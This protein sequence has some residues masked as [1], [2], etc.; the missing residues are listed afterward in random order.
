MGLQY[1]KIPT[2]DVLFREQFIN[3]QYVADNGLT[4]N[5]A[6]TVANGIVLN[7]TTQSAETFFNLDNLSVFSIEAWVSVTSIGVTWQP[8]ICSGFNAGVGVMLSI[9]GARVILSIPT[10]GGYQQVTFDD[11][12]LQPNTPYHIIVTFDG[13]NAVGYV[14]GQLDT[15][16]GTFTK[17]SSGGKKMTI[18]ASKSGGVYGAWSSEELGGTIYSVSIFNRVLTAAEVAD[19]FTQQ[20]FKEVLPKNTTFWLPLRTHYNDGANE[21]TPTLGNINQSI[22]KWGDGSTPTTYPTLLVDNGASFDSG[23]SVR[24]GPFGAISNNKDYSFAA[25]VKWT[26]TSVRLILDARDS[27]PNGFGIYAHSTNVE[28]YRDGGIGCVSG[29]SNINDG[30]WHSIAVVLKYNGANTTYS[31]YVDGKLDGSTTGTTYSTATN[32]NI[33][34]GADYTFSNGFLGSMKF[35]M[36]TNMALTPTQVKWLHDYSFRNFNI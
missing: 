34:V 4:L 35:P 10:G 5:A 6:P 25:L 18:G 33:V 28:V 30:S 15:A 24:C 13:T 12:V 16:T 29:A 8:I 11:V 3:N 17:N 32:A 22:I 36:F 9:N 27:T 20:T 31:V 19:R 2:E 1:P 14:N 23:D 7:G 21:V 26:S